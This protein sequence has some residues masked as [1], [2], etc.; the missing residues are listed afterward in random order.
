MTAKA[1]WL[2]NHRRTSLIVLAALGVLTISYMLSRE[3]HRSAI[4]RVNQAREQIARA[5]WLAATGSLDRALWEDPFLVEAHLLLATAINGHIQSS[6]LMSRKYS[7]DDALSHLDWVLHYRPAS[8]EAHYQ[9]GLALAG[10]ARVQDA[11]AE[12]ATAIPLLDDPTEAL[13][14]RSGLSFHVGD[15]KT[16]MSEVSSAIERHPLVPEY[17]GARAL[18]RE[19]AGDP[20]GARQDRL[21]AHLLREAKASTAKGSWRIRPARRD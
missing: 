21:R 11:R 14:E 9:R 5:D 1:G 19:V 20:R 3:L 13:V 18:Y 16:A 2:P 17:Y 15:Y 8:G 10:L 6:G 7:R 4:G 12:L